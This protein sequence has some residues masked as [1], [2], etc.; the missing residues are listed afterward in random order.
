MEDSFISLNCVI[1]EHIGNQANY[2]KVKYDKDTIENIWAIKYKDQ[3]WINEQN[4]FYQLKKDSAGYYFDVFENDYSSSGLLAFGLVGGLV[5]SSL[6]PSQRIDGVIIR[7][8]EE[9][10]SNTFIPY[11]F[12]TLPPSRV[13]YYFTKYSKNDTEIELMINSKN[14]KLKKGSYFEE[15]LPSRVPYKKNVISLGDDKISFTVKIKPAATSVLLLKRKK[16]GTLICDE[17]NQNMV[18][19]FQKKQDKLQKIK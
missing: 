4:R 2:L 8:R 18:V 16:D 15:V 3:I 6:E 12:P 7:Y 13:I 10:K 11:E 5:Y 1:K 9:K 14:I 19:E 17:L